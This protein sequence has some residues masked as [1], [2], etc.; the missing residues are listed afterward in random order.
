[1]SGVSPKGTKTFVV[2]FENRSTGRKNEVGVLFPLPEDGT[3][4]TV[5]HFFSRPPP[6]PIMSLVSFPTPIFHRTGGEDGVD[7]GLLTQTG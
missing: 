3:Y 6:P 4:F 5:D 1:M 7:R 2:P